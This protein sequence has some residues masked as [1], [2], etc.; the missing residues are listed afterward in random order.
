MLRA[1]NDDEVR[2]RKRVDWKSSLTGITYA[3]KWNVAVVRTKELESCHQNQI[4]MFTLYT[5]EEAMKQ[6]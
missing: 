3:I 1:W 4:N 5:G 6:L 2:D